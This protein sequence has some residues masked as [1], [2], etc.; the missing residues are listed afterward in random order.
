MEMTRGGIN[1]IVTGS[2]TPSA[3]AVKLLEMLVMDSGVKLQISGKEV[4]ARQHGLEI[5]SRHAGADELA[6]KLNEIHQRDPKVF[7][8]AKTMIE[9]LHAQVTYTRKKPSSKISRTVDLIAR[10]AAEKILD[11]R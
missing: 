2:T 10:S 1:G 5:N 11:R 9:S 8:S 3:G 7:K 6:A 4:T